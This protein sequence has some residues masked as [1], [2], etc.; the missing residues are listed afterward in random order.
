VVIAPT[1][2]NFG[3]VVATASSKPHKFTATNKSLVPAHLTTVNALLPPSSFVVSADTC[4]GATLDVKGTPK[5]KCTLD[6]AF[7]P[8]AVSSPAAVTET[9]TINYDAQNPATATLTG[10]GIAPTAK[11]APTTVTFAKTKAGFTSAA[12]TITITNESVGASVTLSAPLASIGP[13]FAIPSGDDACSGMT[14][15]A[16]GTPGAKCIVKAEFTPF[17]GAA[18]GTALTAPLSYNFSVSGNP[19]ATLTATLKGTVK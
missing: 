13:N 18:S 4:S 19:P 7:A 16:K 9:L 1:S 5:S 12:K 17:G 11:I 6:V 3:K 8:A 10:T 15:T 14:L 2:F